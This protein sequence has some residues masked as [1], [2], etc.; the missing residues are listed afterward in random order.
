MH[1]AFSIKVFKSKVKLNEYDAGPGG[2]ISGAHLDFNREM[3]LTDFSICMRFHYKLLGKGYESPG[4]IFTMTKWRSGG[5]NVNGDYAFME[6]QHPTTFFGF[7]NEKTLLARDPDRT[8][9]EIWTSNR[10][11]HFCLA[12]EKKNGL[13][14]FVK[15]GKLMI[16]NYAK[17]QL[18]ELNFPRDVM[19]YIYIGKCAFEFQGSCTGPEGELSDFNMWNK[20]LSVQEMIAFTSCRK[21]LKGNL[22]N[23]ET[24][25]WDITNMTVLDKSKDELCIPHRPGHVLFP[26]QKNITWLKTPLNREI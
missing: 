19:S 22:V 20:A 4:R 26:E 12:Y 23:W 6:A 15:D 14:Q 18:N 7:G 17:G 21:M 16:V 2:P 5:N 1:F 11:A 9:F 25:K 8:D 24:S 3:T 10:W 13:L